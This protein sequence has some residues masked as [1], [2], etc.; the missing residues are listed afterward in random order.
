[1]SFELPEE[2]KE[3]KMIDSENVEELVNLLKNEAKVYKNV[4]INFRRNVERKV[5]KIIT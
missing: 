3:C 5:K 2:K 1:M 4:C